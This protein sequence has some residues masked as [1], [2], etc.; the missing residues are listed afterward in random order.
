MAHGQ[1]RW[2]CDER[3]YDL[4]GDHG[5]RH[6]RDLPRATG[7]GRGDLRQRSKFLALSFDGKN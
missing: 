1:H 3:W 5:R 7:R 6:Q 2:F 4:L